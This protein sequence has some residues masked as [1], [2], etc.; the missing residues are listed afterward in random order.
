MTEVH[1]LFTPFSFVPF[2]KDAGHL[3]FQQLINLRIAKWILVLRQNGEIID[4]VEQ[5]VRLAIKLLGTSANSDT[6][7]FLKERSGSVI[8]V[9]G[10]QNLRI[11]MRK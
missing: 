7:A 2:L 10:K 8:R 5:S 11:Y 9:P 3:R 4:E 1:L 6:E